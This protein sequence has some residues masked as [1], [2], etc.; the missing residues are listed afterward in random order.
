MG[1]EVYKDKAHASGKTSHLKL[2]KS[3]WR[4]WNSLKL[5]EALGGL[6]EQ[7]GTP[8]K[9]PGGYSK[10]YRRVRASN[11]LQKESHNASWHRYRCIQTR[12]CIREALRT[13]SRLR[14]AVED[15]SGNRLSP[16][17]HAHPKVARAMLLSFT[18]SR[19]SVSFTALHHHRHPPSTATSLPIAR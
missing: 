12:Q 1:S 16:H 11:F 7:A 6:L 14:G 2:P 8:P 5:P 4:A 17:S 9:F 18:A 10:R 3:H 13:L 15:K 19:L